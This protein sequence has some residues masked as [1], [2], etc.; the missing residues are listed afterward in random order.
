MT[1]SPY[2][3]D[4]LCSFRNWGVHF[5]HYSILNFPSLTRSPYILQLQAKVTILVTLSLSDCWTCLRLT[6]ELNVCRWTLSTQQSINQ[7]CIQILTQPI[8][9]CVKLFFFIKRVP[10]PLS[11]EITYFFNNL[12]TKQTLPSATP[13]PFGSVFQ[14]PYLSMTEQMQFLLYGSLNTDLL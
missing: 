14:Q 5:N 8:R 10:F 9:T 3:N 12:G 6:Y 13:P 2:V 11:D 1:C 7:T 4:L